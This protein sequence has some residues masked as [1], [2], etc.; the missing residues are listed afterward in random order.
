MKMC[1][2]TKEQETLIKE[3]TMHDMEFLVSDMVMGVVE[4]EK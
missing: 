3:G 1:I 2:L 4:Q